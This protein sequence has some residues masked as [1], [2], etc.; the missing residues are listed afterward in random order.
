MGGTKTQ[1]QVAELAS[2]YRQLYC[3]PLDRRTTGTRTNIIL[4]YNTQ[5]MYPFPLQFP[6][7]L[8]ITSSIATP[9]CTNARSRESDEVK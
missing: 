9:G 2:D 7:A 5:P 4:V 8:P 1:I 3:P 6:I